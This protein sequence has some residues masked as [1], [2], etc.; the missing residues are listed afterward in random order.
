MKV[1][2]HQLSVLSPLLFAVVMDV[3]F[4]ETRCGLPSELLYADDVVLMAPTMKQLGRHVA[5]WKVSLLEKGL[6]V[7]AGKSKVM[8]GSSDEN[9]IV[10]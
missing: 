10:N 8:V 7:I 2:L 1:G 6:N 4:S 3:V 9:I 5:E